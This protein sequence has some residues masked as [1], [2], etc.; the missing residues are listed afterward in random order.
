MA[1]DLFAK[2]RRLTP[3]KA[4]RI[5][6]TLFSK[7]KNSVSGISL[8]FKAGIAV[9]LAAAVVVTPVLFYIDLSGE[10]RS[11]NRFDGDAAKV[12]ANII[13]E[14]GSAKTEQADNT[15]EMYR[16]AGLSFARE[17]DFDGNGR[18]ELML[19]FRSGSAYQAEVWGY[20]GGD[21]VRLYS[22]AANVAANHPEVGYWISLYRHGSEFYI[23]ELSAEDGKTMDLFSLHGGTFKSTRQC[24]YDPVNDIYAEDG[25]IN[26]ADYETIRLS[27]LSASKA[28]NLL[29]SVSAAINSFGAADDG[30]LPVSA[31]SGEELMAQA[32]SNV[33]QDYVSKYGRPQYDSSSRTCFATG[34]CVADLIDFNGDGVNELLT[35]YRFSKKISA[36]DDAGNHVLDTE[37]EYKIEVFRWNGTSAVKAFENEGISEMQDPDDPQRFYILRKNGEKTDICRNTYTYDERT[38]RIWKGASR[39]SEM[40]ENGA[41]SASFTAE[42]NSNYG[43]N[44][45]RINGERVYRREFN[46]NGYAVP[47][48]CND[49]DY[50]EEQYTVVFLQGGSDRGADIQKRISQT[51]KNI[52]DITSAANV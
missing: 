5:L 17:V 19:A 40:D 11:E 36:T 33:V 2:L 50:D 35:V 22:H 47:Y 51:E 1:K 49:E 42:V 14:Y 28:E 12:C 52:D 43:Y 16:M 4:R 30:A 10:N 21:F 41:F 46:A 18:S 34:L 48:F 45:Y 8:G 31:K 9:L 24:E 39:I 3:A 25:K 27:N 20:D 6:K 37:P 13:G 32:Y 44:T 23:G 29:D 7:V 38:Q 26:T 15:G